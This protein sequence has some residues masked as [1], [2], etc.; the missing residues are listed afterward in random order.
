MKNT[1]RGEALKIECRCTSLGL[2]GTE[3]EGGEGGQHAQQFRTLCGPKTNLS[4][5]WTGGGSALPCSEGNNKMKTSF[6][7]V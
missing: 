3:I 4:I 2:W 7:K 6:P 1:D 5:K